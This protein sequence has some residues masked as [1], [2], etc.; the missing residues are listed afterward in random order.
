MAKDE[1]KEAAAEAKPAGN[2][3]MIIIIAIVA[4]LAIGIGVGVAL[5]LLGGDSASEEAAAPAEPVKLPAL[6]LELKPPIIVTYNY[7]GKQRFIQ[8]S[9]SLMARDQAVLDAI[10]LHNPVLRNRLLNLYAAKPFE[11]LATHEGRVGLLDETRTTLNALLQE[12]KVE[13]EVEAVLYQNVVLQ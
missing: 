7:N 2:K 9:L 4:V 3:K 11:S 12:Q 1:K 6:Y 8:V 5:F 13:G 10:E